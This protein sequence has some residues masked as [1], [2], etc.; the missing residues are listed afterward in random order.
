[1]K[2]ASE[3]AK[4]AQEYRGTRPEIMVSGKDKGGHVT[5]HKVTVDDEG[6]LVIY[7]GGIKISVKENNLTKVLSIQFFMLE[8]CLSVIV[9]TNSNLP[10]IE[11]LESFF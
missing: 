7:D 9:T 1:M 5:T 11:Q 2:T 10:R 4:V 6:D 8:L 3:F